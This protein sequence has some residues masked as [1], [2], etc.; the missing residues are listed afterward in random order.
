MYQQ[1]QQPPGYGMGGAI[2][3]YGIPPM[4]PPN[5]GIPPSSQGNPFA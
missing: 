3:G 5:S 1:A 2:G 4:R